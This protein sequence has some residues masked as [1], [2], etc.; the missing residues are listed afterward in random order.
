MADDAVSR[1]EFLGG[2][3]LFRGF[4]ETG[5]LIVSRICR[6]KSIPAS[7][8]IFVQNMVSDSLYIVKSGKVALSI[9]ARSGAE[10]ICGYLSPAESFGELALLFEGRRQVTATAVE[11][12][13]LVEITRRDFA[14]LQ[15]QKPQACLK[16][17]MNIV[18]EF[19]KRLASA[20][21]VLSSLLADKLDTIT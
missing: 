14:A 1:A 2:C 3:E 7:T 5:L 17:M 13:E 16:L 15:K 8:P 6:Q 12:C 9:K 21:G 18:N 11:D 19:G 4:S 20:G 10:R